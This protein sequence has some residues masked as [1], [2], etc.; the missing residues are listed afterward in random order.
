M[1]FFLD[2]LA[3][4]RANLREKLNR[5]KNLV[6]QAHGLNEDHAINSTRRTK[7]DIITVDEPFPEEELSAIRRRRNN[8]LP[9][10]GNNLNSIVLYANAVTFF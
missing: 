10:S 1:E 7:R 2:S 4:T 8:K 5:Y 6:K 9:N 3:V